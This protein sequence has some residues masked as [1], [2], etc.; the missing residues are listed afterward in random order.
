M[1]SSKTPIP[2]IY[3]SNPE[4]WEAFQRLMKDPKFRETLDNIGPDD[5]PSGISGELEHYGENINA[6]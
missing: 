3:A 6:L 2:K 5:E 1:K 4:A